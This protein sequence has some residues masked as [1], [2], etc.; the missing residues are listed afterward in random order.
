MHLPDVDALAAA[1]L[2]SR[3]TLYSAEDL[4]HNQ[5]FEERIRMVNPFST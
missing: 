5:V 4:P 3:E 2:A 1:V